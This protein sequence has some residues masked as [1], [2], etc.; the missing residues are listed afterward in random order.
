MTNVFDGEDLREACRDI[1]IWIQDIPKRFGIRR[2]S[3]QWLVWI[4]LGML[5]LAYAFAWLG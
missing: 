4:A 2:K 5:F 3:E 1:A